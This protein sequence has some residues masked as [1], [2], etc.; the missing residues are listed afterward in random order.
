MPKRGELERILDA[1]HL[2][3]RL[4]PD[5][6][7]RVIEQRGLQDCAELL[8]HI[9]PAQLAQVFDRDLWHPDHP[10]GDDQL[11]TRRFGVWLEVLMESGAAVAAAAVA[12]MDPELV[13]TALSQHLRVF[14]A[15]AVAPVCLAGWRDRAGT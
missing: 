12:A 2:I 11:D 7:L 15:A 4:E 1:P 9:T 5:V 6:L 10:G 8:A 13:V 14:D 3:P